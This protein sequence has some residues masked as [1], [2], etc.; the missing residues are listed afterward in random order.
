[1]SVGRRPVCLTRLQAVPDG[2]RLLY[3]AEDFKSWV[4]LG[5]YARQG[6]ALRDAGE[7]QRIRS[8]PGVCGNVSDCVLAFN[9]QLQF[10]E[11]AL[12]T[13][14]RPMAA[15]SVSGPFWRGPHLRA[16]REIP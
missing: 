15:G 4:F 11:G 16:R 13:S 1:M 3:H 7:H 8:E 6:M 12:Y 9:R 2:G 14:F 10:T 5:A